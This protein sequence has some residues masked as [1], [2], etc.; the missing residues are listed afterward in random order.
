MDVTLTSR[1]ASQARRSLGISQAQVCRDLTMNRSYLSQFENGKYL[2]PEQEQ[3]SLR[4]YYEERGF[5]FTESAAKSEPS[6][7]VSSYQDDPVVR[8]GIQIPDSLD[9]ATAEDL[10]AQYEIVNRR[11]DQL[12]GIDLKKP[13]PAGT[14]NKFFD[15]G[16]RF[17]LDEVALRVQDLL[18]LMAEGY[19]LIR[20]I[21]GDAN[22]DL[23]TSDEP[24][25]TLDFLMNKLHQSTD[26]AEAA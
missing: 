4:D 13:E 14:I 6:Q 23:E 16:K 18:A 5:E 7:A 20:L 26:E 22:Y 15:D 1:K 11:I 25:T 12:A 17:D 19:S 2:L 24:R 3:V 8:D 21:H 10:L 9:E